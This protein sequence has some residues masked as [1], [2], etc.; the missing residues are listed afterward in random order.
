MPSA[1]CPVPTPSSR[2][3]NRNAMKTNYFGPTIECQ[4]EKG[5]KLWGADA[6][7]CVLSLNAEMI[8]GEKKSLRKTKVN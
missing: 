5:A 3:T 4:R 2:R 1:Q 6:E 8:D 7:L